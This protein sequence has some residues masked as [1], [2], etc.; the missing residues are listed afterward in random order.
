MMER[1]DI[2]PDLIPEKFI[3]DNMNDCIDWVRANVEDNVT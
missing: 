1:I 3:F 2:I